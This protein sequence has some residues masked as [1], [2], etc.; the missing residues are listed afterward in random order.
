MKYRLTALLLAPLTAPYAAE[1]ATS[2]I[3]AAFDEHGRKSAQ[4]RKDFRHALDFIQHQRTAFSGEPAFNLKQRVRGEQLTDARLLQIKVRRLRE[5]RA[6]QGGLAHLARP[7]NERR[8]KL[9]GQ[10]PE[11]GGVKSIP[12][13]PQMGSVTSNIK[14]IVLLGLVSPPP[15]EEIKVVAAAAPAISSDW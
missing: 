8:R 11:T 10:R 5:R 6:G 15:V 12:H 7:Q 3:G 9:P 2:Q 1:I 14:A 13:T 4:R